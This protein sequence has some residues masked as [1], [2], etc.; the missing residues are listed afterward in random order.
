MADK[1]AKKGIVKDS[2]TERTLNKIENHLDT[3]RRTKTVSVRLA[4]VATVS[5]L[6]SSVWD[7]P[8][9]WMSVKSILMRFLVGAATVATPSISCRSAR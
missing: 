2:D 8:P 7:L 1:D 4:H 3:I 9:T 5:E 6:L